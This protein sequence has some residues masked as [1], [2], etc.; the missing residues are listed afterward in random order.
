MI[1]FPVIVAWLAPLANCVQLVP[2]VY[3][4]W[5]TQRVHDLS[6]YSL[7]LL[8]LTSLLWLL[9]GYFISDISLMAAGVVSVTVNL[10]M[11]TLYVMYRTKL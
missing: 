5:T 11:V 10:V 8:L 9:H 7:L 6:L 1:S 3:K 4:T 2:Q